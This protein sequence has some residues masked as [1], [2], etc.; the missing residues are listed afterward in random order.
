MKT[1]TT[2][3]KLFK[4]FVLIFAGLAALLYTLTMLFYF[5]NLF[6]TTIF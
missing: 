6:T 5:Y 4:R 1:P 3:Q 2:A